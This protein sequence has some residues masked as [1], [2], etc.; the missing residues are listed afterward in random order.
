MNPIRFLPSGTAGRCVVLGAGS[1]VGRALVAALRRAG[2]ATVG[3][4]SADID[5]TAPAAGEALVDR[6]QPDDTLIVLAALTPDRGGRERAGFLANI[7]MA[8]AICEALSRRPVAQVV[9]V[10]SDAV[11]PL[12]ATP[13]AVTDEGSPAAPADLYGAAHRSRELMLADICAPRLLVLRAT[14]IFGA[15]DTHNAYGVTRF[16]RQARTARRITV[17]GAGEETREHV[18]V[19]DLARLIVALVDRRAVGLVNAVAGRS[20]RYADL[21][22][23]VRGVVGPDVVIDA[24]PRQAPATYRRFE[25]ARLADALPAFAWTPLADAVRCVCDQMA[26]GLDGGGGFQ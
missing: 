6:L 26:A 22:D 17:F 1:F 10:S 4:G 5:L 21:A 23:L 7:A 15:A 25:A 8:A 11:Y 3:L 16:L 20:V 18:W 13:E 2:R 24:A 9:Y 19:A 14:L 12:S